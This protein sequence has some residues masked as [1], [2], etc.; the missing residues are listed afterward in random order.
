MLLKPFPIEIFRVFSKNIFG[1]Q[2]KNHFKRKNLLK[3]SDRGSGRRPSNLLGDWAACVCYISYEIVGHFRPRK[4]QSSCRVCRLVMVSFSRSGIQ[5]ANAANRMPKF[6]LVRFLWDFENG[7]FRVQD[8]IFFSF[9]SFFFSFSRP[10]P[11]L[12]VFG[13]FMGSIVIT[14]CPKWV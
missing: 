3:S 7:R 1:N 12:P 4:K 6:V 8:E 10:F 9:S 2:L 13:C 14:W 11:V 5:E